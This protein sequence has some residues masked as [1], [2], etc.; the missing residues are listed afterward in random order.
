VSNHSF[1][2]DKFEGK[3]RKQQM[4]DND[5]DFHKTF[6]GKFPSPLAESAIPTPVNVSER[7]TLGID[8][9]KLFNQLRSKIDPV[10]LKCCS[11]N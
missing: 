7:E 2:D 10:T 4:M 8:L 5:N 6:L 9:E 1:E 11:F 3:E